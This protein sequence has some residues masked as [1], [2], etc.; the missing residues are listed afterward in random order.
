MRRLEALADSL[1][2][3]CSALDPDSDAYQLRNPILLRAFSPRHD[4]DEKGR[5]VFKTFIAG[6]ENALLDLKIKCSGHSR[7]KLSPESELVVLLTTYGHPPT[8]IR[9]VIKFIRRA[10]KDS[11]IPLNVNLGWFMDG[12]EFKN[13]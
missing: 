12:E 13:V 9:Y 11:N 4:R 2:N 3:L 7:A 10:L 5:R 6:Y 8:S 1:S